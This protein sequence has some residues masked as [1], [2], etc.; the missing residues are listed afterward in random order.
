MFNPSFRGDYGR[1]HPCSEGTSPE[2]L[3]VPPST[4]GSVRTD[5]LPSLKPSSPSL[6]VNSTVPLAMK[7]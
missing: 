5:S 6:A 7:T 2:P 4:S 1:L 3:G